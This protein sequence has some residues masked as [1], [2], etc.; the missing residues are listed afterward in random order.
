MENGRRHGGEVRVRSI[1]IVGGGT[2]GWMAACRLASEF[3]SG[4]VDILVIESSDIATVG[5]GEATVPAIRDY[6]RN[7]GLSDAEVLAATNGTLKLGILFDGWA[8]EGSKI[9]HPFGQYGM[10]ARG[11]AFHQYLASAASAGVDQ[12]LGSYALAT[13]LAAKGRFMLPSDQ[14]VHDFLHF[15][16]AMHFDATLFGKLL[17]DRAKSLGVRHADVRIE[18]VVISDSSFTIDAVKSICGQTFTADF[19]IDCTGS[20]SLLLGKA[21][22]VPYVDWSGFLPCDSA[23]AVQSARD[24]TPAPYTT[25]TACKAGWRWRIPLR[26]RTGNGYVFSSRHLS[27][28][29]ANASLLTAVGSEA[30]T[31]PRLIQFTTGHRQSFWK[32]N[33]LG[34]GLAAG[35]MEPLESTS[36]VLVQ[37]GIERF[38]EFFPTAG[39]DTVMAREFNRVTTLEYARIRDFIILHYWGNRQNGFPMWDECRAMK[40]PDALRHKVDLFEENGHLINYDWESFQG[41]S[42]LSIY[43]G[44][45]IRPKRYDPRANFFSTDAIA[46]SLERMKATIADQIEAALPASDFLERYL[47]VSNAK[48][49]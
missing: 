1:V 27:V 23:I 5:V 12:D 14:P 6:I 9:F 34:L 8:G 31:Q 37:S 18:E 45:G 3:P 48:M 35:F 49:P 4:E 15:D 13:A 19:F 40:L 30:T 38:L 22:G 26:N 39:T 24:E 41:P 20:R 32:G 17:A 43:S 10:R 42:W 2:A 33:C 44:L 47:S 11:V 7:I 28:D 25:S 29:E 16:W 21:L 36:L 46:S